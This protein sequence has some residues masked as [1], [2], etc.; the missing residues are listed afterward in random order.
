MLQT[1]PPMVS[2]ILATREQ[3][4]SDAIT[5]QRLAAQYADGAR[6]C[7]EIVEVTNDS[8]NWTIQ[9]GDDR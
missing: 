9:Y 2:L 3:I 4:E 6:F 7:A 1:L 5:W 8:D